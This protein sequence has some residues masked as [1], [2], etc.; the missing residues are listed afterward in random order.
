M[1]L[2]TLVGLV[3]LTGAWGLSVTVFARDKHG[4][5]VTRD[6]VY[7]LEPDWSSPCRLESDRLRIDETPAAGLAL[8]LPVRVIASHRFSDPWIRIRTAE[9]QVTYYFERGARGL[10]YVDLTQMVADLAQSAGPVRVESRGCRYSVERLLGFRQ[11]P[12]DEMRLLIVAPHPDDAELAAFGLYEAHASRATIVTVSPGE[13]LTDLKRQYIRG[14][15]NDIVSGTRR[16][17]QIRSWDAY[18]VPRWAGVDADDT[19]SLGYF[20]GTLTRM[21][22]QPDEV[23]P[24]PVIDRASPADFRQFNTTGLASD[25]KVENRW[26]D[27]VADIAHIIEARTPDMIVVPHPQL[28][29]HP[30]HQ[31]TTAA[32]LEACERAAHKVVYRMFYS[33][34]LRGARQFPLGPAGGATGLV[35]NFE[36][37]VVGKKVCSLPLSGEGRRRKAC[38]LN[39]MHDLTH[40]HRPW[41]RFKVELSQLL[42]WRCRDVYGADTYFRTALRDSELFLYT[43]ARDHPEA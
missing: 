28:D 15:D 1:V 21:Q 38:A 9:Q 41:K 4:Y 18:T 27:L 7:D 11:P 42:R 16:K 37:D 43:V 5:D 3:L 33:N 29:V 23:I 22:Q 34:H 19:I 2:E 25:E 32:V 13:R 35:P 24:H 36:A 6:Y 20:D 40:P 10:R 12:L 14:L 39:F 8:I 30:D 31:A 26:R 17:G